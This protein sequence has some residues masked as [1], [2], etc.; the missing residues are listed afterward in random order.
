MRFEMVDGH[1]IIE[2]DGRRVLLDTGS[3]ASLGPTGT[4]Q[5]CG[6]PVTLADGGL[7]I[8]PAQIGEWVGTRVDVLLG[9]DVLSRLRFTIDLDE[10]GSGGHVRFERPAAAGPSIDLAEFMGIPI[11][12]V[13]VGDEP[14]RA[15]VDIGA[16]LSYLDAQMAAAFA[17]TGSERDFYPG[18]GAFRT[19][20]RVVPIEIAG[21]TVELRCGVLPDSLRMTLA[22]ADTRAILGTELLR[23][24]AITFALPDGVLMLEPRG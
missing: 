4:W 5:F 13:T 12:T 20:V 3:P 10:D 14:V 23:H 16:K 7:G 9:A 21:C 19:D 6:V 8:T 15:I 11:A 22:M 17:V 18:I 2:Y 1:V 24:G